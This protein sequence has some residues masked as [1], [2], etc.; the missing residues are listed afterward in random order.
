MFVKGRNISA[1]GLFACYAREDEPMTAEQIAA[2]RDLPVEVVLE[3]IAYCQ[4]SPPE[5]ARDFALEDALL[6]A[7]GLDAPGFDGRLRTLSP[8]EK[9][10]IVRKF[11]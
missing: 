2:D 1:Q 10:A 11:D 3:A 9:T 4:S 5:L 7:R 6:R 8:E